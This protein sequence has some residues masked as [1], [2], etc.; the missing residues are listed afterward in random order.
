MERH[1]PYKRLR[2]HGAMRGA[3]IGYGIGAY[4]LFVPASAAP[5]LLVGIGLQL[6]V[7]VVRRLVAGREGARA[8]PPAAM[9]VFELVVDGITVLLFALATFRGI[10][11]SLSGI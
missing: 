9:P 8:L 10:G 4:T 3:I 6:L 5:S 7:L 2:V 11:H 1:S